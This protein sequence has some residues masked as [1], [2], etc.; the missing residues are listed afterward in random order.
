MKTNVVARGGG[1]LQNEEKLL[2]RNPLNKKK[3]THLK[4]TKTKIKNKN[5]SNS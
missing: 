3:R 2:K 4:R 5:K 1:E